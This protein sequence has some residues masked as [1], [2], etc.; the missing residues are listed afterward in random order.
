MIDREMGWYVTPVSVKA[1]AFTTGGGVV[2]VRNERCEWELPGGWPDETDRSLEDALRREIAEELSVAVGGLRLTGATLFEP[3]P[4]RRVTLIF[5]SC[6]VGTTD[7]RLSSEH[8]DVLVA[9]PAALPDDLAPTYAHAI[10]E[11]VAIAGD[12]HRPAL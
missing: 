5:Y 8:I 3:I 7:F 6:I 10:T 4:G 1:I 12:R 9:D 2:L 11:S